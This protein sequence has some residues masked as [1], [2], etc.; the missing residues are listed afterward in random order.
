MSVI[1]SALFIVAIAFFFISIV[2]FEIGTRRVKEKKAHK[3]YDKIGF[4]LL[5]ISIFFTAISVLFAI[6]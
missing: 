3:K 6:I 5:Y 1:S 2:T 4:R